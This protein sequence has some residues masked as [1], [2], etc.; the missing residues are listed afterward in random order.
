M[1]HLSYLMEGEA[2]ID[3]E[4]MDLGIEIGGKSDSGS[5][6]LKIPEESLAGYIA[7]VKERLTKG[8]WNEI[9]GPKQILFIFKFE[10]GHIEEYVLSPENE[11]HIAKL[12][13]EFNG[14]PPEKTANV[15]RYISDNDFYHEYMLEHY[16]DMELCSPTGL[17]QNLI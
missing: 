5:R 15:Y 7:L 9:I 13:S 4:L 2:I 10:D 12:C 11:Q 8:F 16:A 6:M 14:E 3:S 17:I 1:K